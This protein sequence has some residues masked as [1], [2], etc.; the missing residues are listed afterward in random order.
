MIIES[1]SNGR[2]ALARWLGWLEHRPTHQEVAGL[3]PGWGH[4]LGLWV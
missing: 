4:V 1:E 3:I 2:S